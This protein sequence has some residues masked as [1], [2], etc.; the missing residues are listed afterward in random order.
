M[1]MGLVAALFWPTV[2]IG[3]LICGSYGLQVVGLLSGQLIDKAVLLVGFVSCSL[4][5]EP[6]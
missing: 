2:P 4:T 6:I 3:G 1:T 5:S